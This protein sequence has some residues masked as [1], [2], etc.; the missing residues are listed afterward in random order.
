MAGQ[1]PLT[2]TSRTFELVLPNIYL[3]CDLLEHTKGL[4]LVLSSVSKRSFCDGPVLVL[5]Q[6]P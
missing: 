1:L 2:D 4:V 3:L 6:R 5:Y